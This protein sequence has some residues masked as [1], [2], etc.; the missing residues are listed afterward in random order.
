MTPI[1][2]R[3]AAV[4]AVALGLASACATGGPDPGSGSASASAS[5]PGPAGSS[6][7]GDPTGPSGTASAS[8]H[9]AGPSAGCTAATAPTPGTTEEQVASGGIERSYQLIVPAVADGSTPLPI[10][11]GL[12]SLTVDHRIVPAMSG[13][14]DLAATQD[15]IGVA[16]SGRLNAGG[17]PY[18]DASPV[19]DNADVTFIADLLDHLEDTLCVDTGQVFSMGMSNG[20]HLSSL[21]ACR[22]PDRIAAIAPIAGV[23]MN[24]PCAGAPVPVIAFHGSADPIVPF[25]GGGLSSVTIADQNLY[26]GA[27]PPGTAVPSGVEE[28]MR[29][30]A[31]HNGCAPDVTDE[32]IAANVRLRRWTGCA[33]P[34]ELYIVDGAGHTWPGKPQAAFEAQFGTGTT[35]IDA[36]ALSF[37]FFFD[38]AAR[39]T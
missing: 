15:F 31:Q 35:E 33:A 26:H 32:Q 22:L 6:V 7:P 19:A 36:S 29:R 9:A 34:T 21:L 14:G 24:E 1:A 27:L 17:L 13:F 30:W 38:P 3:L 23:E 4:A 11:L 12:H 8:E 25:G 39:P 2:R 28:S 10:V 37:A 18:W 16:P 20:A 5:T